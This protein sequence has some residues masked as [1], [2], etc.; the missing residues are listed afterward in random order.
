[1]DVKKQI[2]DNLNESESLTGHALCKNFNIS[3]QAL[4]KHIKALIEAGKIIKHGRTR[5][6][7]YRIGAKPKGSAVENLCRTINL[8]GAHED[9]IFD[10]FN[11]IL[12]TKK[13][14]GKKIYDILYYSFTE[15]LNNAIDHSG[16]EKC[17]I[18]IS[19]DMYKVRFTIRD[20]GIG[21]FSSIHK[22][23]GLPDEN[24]AIGELIKGKTT[25]MKERHS[26]EGIFFTSKLGDIVSFRSHG[27]KIVFD[28]VR[29]DVFV[30]KKKFI[31]GTEVDFEISRHSK[32]RIDKCFHQFAPEEFDYK[33]DRTSILVKLFQRDYVSR[34]EAK[35]LVSGLDK[36]KEV[37]LDFKDVDLMGQGFADELFRVFMSAHPKIKMHVRNAGDPVKIILNHV[38]DNNINDR[39]T[40]D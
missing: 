38:V 33:F 16:S 6:A 40:M 35:R 21:V 26:G 32:R 18:S 36:F 13:M 23:F 4:N 27:L 10:D 24:S 14:L 8:A 31:A 25:T 30:Q 28:N 1:M 11:A 12:N 22:K 17:R 39:L 15:M 7:V 2:L 9:Q 37:I 34:S 3:R 29:R 5:G 20:N 19:L